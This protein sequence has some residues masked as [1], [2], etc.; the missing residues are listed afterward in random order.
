MNGWGNQLDR[1]T[2]WMNMARTKTMVLV[3]QDHRRT[4][5]Q[6]HNMQYEVEETWLGTTGQ[7]AAWA[8]TP[9]NRHVGGIAIAVHPALARYA[10][11]EEK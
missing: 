9:G 2:L 10:C 3:M 7:E 8:Y 6:K 11:H 5:Q 1:K 4:T